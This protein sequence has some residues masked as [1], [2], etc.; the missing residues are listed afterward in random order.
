M[1]SKSGYA[2]TTKAW[3]A[4]VAG[5]VVTVFQELQSKLE[6]KLNELGISYEIDKNG[7]LLVDDMVDGKKIFDILKDNGFNF[8]DAKQDFTMEGLKPVSDLYAKKGGQYILF[9]DKG[10]FALNDNPLNSQVQSL[11]GLG[12][13]LG[14]NTSVKTTLKTSKP[15]TS[16]KRKFFFRSYLNIVDSN[17]KLASGLVPQSLSATDVFS[18]FSNSGPVNLDNQINNIIE[19]S[20]GIKNIV[21]YSDTKARMLGKDKGKGGFLFRFSADDLKGF[22]YEIAKGIKGKEGDAALQFF[23]ENIH[24]PYDAGMQAINFEQIKLM[25]DFKSLKK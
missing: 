1:G 13:T 19:K 2:P 22:T 18:K 25:D 17:G 7:Q 9:G 5:R 24:R 14:L 11:I 10:M 23:K 4:D 15:N 12:Q 6:T 3:G 16:G 20:S 8:S 21:R